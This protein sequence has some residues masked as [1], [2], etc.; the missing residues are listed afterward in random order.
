MKQV[1]FFMAMVLTASSVLAADTFKVKVS[2]FPNN[3]KLGIHGYYRV[4]VVL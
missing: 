1:L 4:V 2:L 3:A